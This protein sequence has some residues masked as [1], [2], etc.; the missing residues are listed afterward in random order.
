MDDATEE[1]CRA[2]LRTHIKASQTLVLVTHKPRLLDLVDRLIV[3][4]PQGIVA[5]GPKA[6]VLAHLQQQA[7]AFAEAQIKAQSE[8]LAASDPAGRRATPTTI[9]SV[10][11][12]QVAAATQGDDA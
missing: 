1:R 11:R 3:L 2:A 5:D 8:T 12:E 7:L 4:T 9:T 6:A 10:Q